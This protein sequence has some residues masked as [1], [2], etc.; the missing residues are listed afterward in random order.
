[1]Q[2]HTDPPSRASKVGGSQG[3][4]G[5]RCC[6]ASDG[7]MPVNA[8]LRGGP[9]IDF[10]ASGMDG[11]GGLVPPSGASADAWTIAEQEYTMTTVFDPLQLSAVA[12]DV[13]AA[14]RSTPRA[15]AQRQRARLARLLDAALPGSAFYRMD[16]SRM[17]GRINRAGAMS[18]TI[19]REAASDS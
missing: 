16:G 9:G 8:S 7:W 11:G 12:L 19:W 1:M 4:Q 14:A 10:G 6:A 3:S 5:L 15:I 13:G 2:W 18:T 17:H